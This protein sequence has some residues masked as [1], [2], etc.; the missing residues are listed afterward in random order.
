MTAS[1]LGMVFVKIPAGTFL[2]GSA[3]GEADERPVRPVTVSAFAMSVTPV[4]NAQYER[5]RPEHRAARAWE[6]RV[7]GDDE[8]CTHVSHQD[9]MDYCAWLSAKTGETFRLPTEA[10]WEYACRAGGEADYAYGDALP[11]GYGV[12][13]QDGLDIR[14]CP[15]TVGQTPP[16]AFVLTDMHGLVEEWCL[17]W[18]APYPKD[19]GSDPGG[20]ADGLYRVT[21]GGSVYAD[22]AHLRSARRMAALPQSRNA[23]TGFR[24]VRSDVTPSF[25]SVPGRTEAWRVR[26]PQAAARVAPST[27]EPLF[28][29][30]LAYVLPPRD[31]E[32]PFYPHNHVPTLCELGD[33][34]LL[35]AWFSTRKECGREM[36][37]LA[38]RF[39]KDRGA[40]SEADLFFKVPG[41]NM[42]CAALLRGAGGRIY[43]F[44]GIGIGSTEENLMLVVRASDDDG[45]T[46]TRP[47]PVDGRYT[48]HKPINQPSLDTEGRL[49]VP[50]DTYTKHGSAQ[51][52][53]SVLY[54][55]D[56][57]GERFEERTSYGLQ[58]EN[59]LK[60]G[61][62]AGWIAGVHGAV[63]ARS[64]GSLYA[65][66]R[67]QCIF[68][69]HTVEGRMPVSVSEDG[70]RLWRYA[71]SPFP[72]IGSG[73][74]HALLRLREGPVVMFSFT[75]SLRAQRRG[76]A[77][78]LELTDGAGS[79]IRGFGLYA[80]M[81]F[82]EGE[83]WP[84]QRLI[85]PGG[86]AREWDIGASMNAALLDDTHGQPAGYMQA[87]Q[88]ADGVIHLIS[89]RLHY[90]LNLAWLL[91]P[92]SV[93]VTA[94]V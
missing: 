84:V 35:A 38:S 22:A 9:A 6:D 28:L 1:S 83:T 13:Q 24:V 69:G 73:Q 31:P 57:D 45:E 37:V 23:V 86:P 20:C 4:T 85:T 92:H 90:R 61:E 74:R 63:L 72:P 3:N 79:V 33:G 71:P 2:M 65:L 51:G 30:P 46:W 53:G 50:C 11:E 56:P 26:S 7:A 34:D 8:A 10:E 78:G 62:C 54:R 81:S 91:S 43:H 67:S 25:H 94:R 77:R 27:A 21:R 16:N 66:G 39:R 41:R 64:D 93:R 14:P 88:A 60:N 76:D 40:W 44:N 17:D 15:L 36:V 55:G 80:A 49:L 89:S 52:M 75:D 5:F 19:A 29:P 58:K 12:C 70:G 47:R 82:D 18:Y 48:S 68:D 87:V 32:I 59:F 42:S